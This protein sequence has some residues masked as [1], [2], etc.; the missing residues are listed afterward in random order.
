MRSEISTHP[1]LRL[2]LVI[3]MVGWVVATLPASVSANPLPKVP[4][5]SSVGTTLQ[6]NS[7]VRVFTYRLAHEGNART[8]S[9]YRGQSKARPLGDRVGLFRWKLALNREWVAIAVKEATGRS[10]PAF[11]HV[12][13]FNAQTGAIRSHSAVPRFLNGDMSKLLDQFSGRERGIIDL[14][15]TRRGSAAWMITPPEGYAGAPATLMMVGAADARP[16]SVPVDQATDLDIDSLALSTN[17]ATLYWIR[18]G[19]LH[20]APMP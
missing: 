19:Q 17:E 11:Y 18:G 2:L 5:Q 7:L 15:V 16:A 1:S 8:W 10:G 9:C 20:S 12:R 4:C 13:I 3:A 14:V 6:A